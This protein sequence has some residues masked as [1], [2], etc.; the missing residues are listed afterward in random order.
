MVSMMFKKGQREDVKSD[1]NTQ[2]LLKNILY[3]VW[4]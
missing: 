3:F 2:R 1:L 4:V